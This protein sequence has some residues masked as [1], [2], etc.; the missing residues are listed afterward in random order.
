MKQIEKP[1]ID[2]N[3]LRVPDHVEAIL[4]CGHMTVH[5]VLG[6]VSREVNASAEEVNKATDW[7]NTNG[8]ILAENEEERIENENER[9]KAEGY[10]TRQFSDALNSV[11]LVTPEQAQAVIELTETVRENIDK[12]KEDADRSQANA[13]AAQASAAMAENRALEAAASALASKES[14]E[15][16]ESYDRYIKDTLEEI[17]GSGDVPAATVAQVAENTAEINVNKESINDLAKDINRHEKAIYSNIFVPDLEK[18]EVIRELYLKNLQDGV[19]YLFIYRYEHNAYYPYGFEVRLKS[20]TSVVI[21]SNLSIDPLPDGI[22]EM[23]ESNNSG[24]SGY[25]YVDWSK[26]KQGNNP[27]G[28]LNN[29]I[30]GN[31]FNS[32][33]ILNKLNTK[34]TKRLSFN[35]KE[36]G[37]IFCDGFA[38]CRKSADGTDQIKNYDLVTQH[39]DYKIEGNCTPTITDRTFNYNEKGLTPDYFVPIESGSKLTYDSSNNS[40]YCI[41]RLPDYDAMVIEVL[42]DDFLLVDKNSFIDI[43]I[44]NGQLKALN[45][46][47]KIVGNK[48][49][50]FDGYISGLDQNDAIY[51]GANH[52]DIGFGKSKKITI[53]CITLLEHKGLSQLRFE[54][55]RLSSNDDLLPLREAW[56]H[57]LENA[58]SMID[59][60]IDSRI[61]GKNFSS[62]FQT[63]PSGKV[64]SWIVDYDYGW[65]KNKAGVRS[66]STRYR[67]EYN[68]YDI[69]N[70]KKYKQRYI[71]TDFDCFLPLPTDEEINEVKSR[72]KYSH[73]I[74]M[75]NDDIRLQYKDQK[76]PLNAD[77]KGSVVGYY[78]DYFEIWQVHDSV[79]NSASIT[80]EGIKS[81]GASPNFGIMVRDGKIYLQL[82]TR[83]D[84]C[85]VLVPGGN[86]YDQTE[87]VICEAIWDKWFHVHVEYFPCQFVGGLGHIRVCIDN[88]EISSEFVNC[89][90]GPDYTYIWKTGLYVSCYY[91][92]EYLISGAD[93]E[94]EAMGCY[95]PFYPIKRMYTKNTTYKF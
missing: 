92:N 35:Y 24:V 53:G 56:Q 78:K 7:V 32:P 1:N 40:E 8:K 3:N 77:G 33:S 82:M 58:M 43:K 66:K 85:P 80:D 54:Q 29:E 75:S 91:N 34:K 28:V 83:K 18:R 6:K 93:T 63:I 95:T 23:K 68:W 64:C 14:A 44:S 41:I 27:S 84:T 61:I 10:R 12:V 81:Y 30:C 26:A 62:K 86:K 16:T 74:E 69:D 88:N 37:V 39:F 67:S 2:Q 50:Y 87:I 22:L 46:T 11:L 20:D 55:L 90:G 38:R 19:E 57:E 59:N 25:I 72:S 60:P 79:Y 94:A 49:L 4:D 17:K 52:L 51:I 73:L 70:Q 21:C 5:Q 13:D 9:E 76:S 45:T 47:I 65:S 15:K 71:E 48:I 42:S 89:N 36:Y 31:L